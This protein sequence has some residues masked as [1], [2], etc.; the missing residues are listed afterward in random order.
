MLWNEFHLEP[1]IVPTDIKC[2]GNTACWLRFQVDE[3]FKDFEKEKVVVAA[4]AVPFAESWKEEKT[5]VVGASGFDRDCEG[6]VWPSSFPSW[7][8]ALLSAHFR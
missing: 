4:G 7:S 8:A 1:D 3:L 6:L 5:V 2:L